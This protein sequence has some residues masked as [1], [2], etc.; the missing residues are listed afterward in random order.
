MDKLLE[1][2]KAESSLYES[3]Y[4]IVDITEII[5]SVSKEFNTVI[6]NKKL[7]F[8][9]DYTNLQKFNI[10]TDVNSIKTAY[11][12]ILETS[13]SMTD[14]GELSVRIF[15][16]DEV[17]RNRYHITADKDTSYVAVVIKDSGCGV[18]VEDIKHLC[19]PYSQLGKDSKNLL[20]AFAL[21]TA[22]IL[23][24]R[25]GGFIDINS[26]VREGSEYIIIL[27]TEKA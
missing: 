12:N 14:N 8:D 25:A 16:P 3:D 18:N 1:F 2:S 10:Y 27:P 11:K 4:R 19:D 6:E 9:V 7:S 22:S 13:L 24:K 26:E 17:M 5:K 15:H 21:G 23:V 20:R